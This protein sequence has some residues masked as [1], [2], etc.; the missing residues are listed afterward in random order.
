MNLFPN[1]NWH[2]MLKVLLSTLTQELLVLTSNLKIT[3]IITR[4]AHWFARSCP[5][6]LIFTDRQ[7][8]TSAHKRH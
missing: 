2:L 5:T 6:E 7:I 4:V 1:K 8:L 3:S